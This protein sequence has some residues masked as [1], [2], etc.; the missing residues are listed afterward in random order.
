MKIT[1]F[2]RVCKLILLMSG[3][4]LSSIAM[5]L[6]GV[7]GY[8]MAVSAAFSVKLDRFL[9]EIRDVQQEGRLDGEILVAK[10]GKVLL[11]LQSKDIES[12]GKAG[13]PQFM[14]G[15]LS[16][17]FFAVAL[18]KALYD[19]SSG[20]TE[21]EK[22]AD[23]KRQLYVPISHFLPA[24]APV[25]SGEMPAWANV[26]TLHQL[27]NHTSGIPNHTD[28]DGFGFNNIKE[29]GEK[30][31]ESPR[32]VSQIVHLV[33]KE[34][35][36]FTPGTKFAYC[37]TG[38]VLIAEVIETLVKMPSARYV[39]EVIFKPLGLH[40]TVNPEIGNWHALRKVEN[41]FR[42]VPEQMY[43]PT[44]VRKGSY[45]PEYY[46]DMANAI[47]AGSII[48]TASDL[49]KWNLALHK[50]QSV[51]PKP[52]YELLMTPNL[53]EYAYGIGVCTSKQDTGLMFVH[54]GLIDTY[55]TNL[56]YLPE[57]DLSIIMLSNT[58]CDWNKVDKEIDRMMIKL[59]KA[60]PDWKER[61]KVC[62]EKMEKKYQNRRGINAINELLCNFLGF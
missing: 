59:E 15:S 56:F 57:E 45:A 29:P 19:T 22:I 24:E 32:E 9:N 4:V 20:I 42:L 62:L 48:S 54:T 3:V 50:K 39:E 34:G 60:I 12:L 33:S 52:L 8:D 61:E 46:I 14:I 27:L 55:N 31:F 17:Q 51:L 21:D 49:L 23:V 5:P 6:E 43:D 58:A 25:W 38:Y 30:F 53:D 36:E 37:N 1:A 18:L 44:G 26:V 16:K 35:L 10:G 40:S 2:F 13:E 11:H 47:G 7:R 41:L 28:T